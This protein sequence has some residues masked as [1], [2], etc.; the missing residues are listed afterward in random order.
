MKSFLFSLENEVSSKNSK[1]PLRRTFILKI[2]NA[3]GK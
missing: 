2:N 3:S 1:N